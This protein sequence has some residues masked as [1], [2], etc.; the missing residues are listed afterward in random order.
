MFLRDQRLY[1]LSSGLRCSWQ[2]LA[3]FRIPGS[4]DQLLDGAAVVPPFL[5]HIHQLLF[6]PGLLDPLDVL[7]HAGDGISLDLGRLH[8][9]SGPLLRA[10]IG[11][12]L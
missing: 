2:N 6:L 5:H 11:F 12:S 7:I 9:A 10:L 3:A 4:S 8:Q 1:A